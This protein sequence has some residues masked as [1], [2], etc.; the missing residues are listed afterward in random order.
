MA[1]LHPGLHRITRS[2]QAAFFAS[3]F[4][5]ASCRSRHVTL[6]F[7]G[8]ERSETEMVEETGNL[9]MAS[10]GEMTMARLP[11]RLTGASVE[12]VEAGSAV[13]G[14]FRQAPSLARF[15]PLRGLG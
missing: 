4:R 13:D 10:S 1:R 9:P 5:F 7:L 12:C 15:R 14:L 2:R 3:R 11:P 8:F 6:G